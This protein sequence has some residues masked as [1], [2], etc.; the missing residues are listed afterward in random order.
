MVGAMGEATGMKAQTV[1]LVYP[2][3]LVCLVGRIEN[4]FIWFV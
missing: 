1:R 3:D 4:R 2:V